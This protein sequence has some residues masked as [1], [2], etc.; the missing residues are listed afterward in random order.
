MQYNGSRV[1]FI[2]WRSQIQKK[3]DFEI[4]R[5]GGNITRHSERSNE[6]RN[7]KRELYL[8]VR[9]TLKYT[10]QSTYHCT[11]SQLLDRNKQIKVIWT[12]VWMRCLNLSSTNTEQYNNIKHCINVVWFYAPPTFRRQTIMLAVRKM[13]S[14][15]SLACCSIIDRLELTYQFVSGCSLKL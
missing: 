3:Q 13:L 11:A 5:N 9:H 12:F 8:S 10:E 7:M 1:L 4:L 6:N 14:E 2:L 15:Q